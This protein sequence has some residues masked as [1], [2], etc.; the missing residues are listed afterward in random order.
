MT[1]LY[2]IDYE[3][4]ALTSDPLDAVELMSERMQHPAWGRHRE[5]APCLEWDKVRAEMR[6]EDKPK[7]HKTVSCD[8]CV[9]SHVDRNDDQLLE[10]SPAFC[11]SQYVRVIAHMARLKERKA[12]PLPVSIAQK[13]ITYLRAIWCRCHH[14]HGRIELK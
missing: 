9:W 4:L 8:N 14:K 10:A 7:G 1:S 12:P 3:S 5:C 2:S 6:L 11:R 13:R